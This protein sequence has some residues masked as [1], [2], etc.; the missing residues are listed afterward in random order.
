MPVNFYLDYYHV[1]VP[2]IFISIAAILYG[3]SVLKRY[4]GAETIEKCHEVGSYYLSIIG[5]F[6]AV[7]LGLIVV[8]AMTKFKGA[9]LSVDH[10]VSSLIR[11]YSS[12]ERFPERRYR[13]ESDVKNYVDEVIK[14]EFPMMESQG[15]A[16]GK[17]RDLALQIMQT[18]KSIE[19]VTENQ[20][21]V[22]PILLTEVADLLTTRWERTRGPN[23]G[24]PAVEWVILI[25]GGLLTIILTF[26]FTIES[27]G[28]HM[29][30]RAGVALTILMS[31]YLTFLFG[32]PFSGDLKISSDPYRLV[33][34]FAD[35]SIKQGAQGKPDHKIESP[36]S[37]KIQRDLQKPLGIK[38]RPG[39]RDAGP[40]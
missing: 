24:E 6:Y 33:Y 1:G 22:F 10:E 15:L 16:D 19:P 35:W 31:L 18:V 20:K 34:D 23:L 2:A 32:S 27:H 13:L 37:N 17:A 29:F 25:I 3:Q 14:V 11:I 28:I 38:K 30:M 4:L 36:S 39:S 9:Q 40:G 5:T 7:L 21:A 26:F 8:D 12:A